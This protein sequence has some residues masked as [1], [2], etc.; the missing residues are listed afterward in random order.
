MIY[1]K[2]TI[3]LSFFTGLS[4]LITWYFDLKGVKVLIPIAVFGI[5]GGLIT[6]QI[7][8]WNNQDS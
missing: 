3:S 8:F 7:V 1:L 2:T 5:V 4:G 6:A